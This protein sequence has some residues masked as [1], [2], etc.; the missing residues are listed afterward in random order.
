MGIPRRPTAALLLLAY[1]AAVVGLPLP[2]PARP[3]QEAPPKPTAPSCC[4]CAGSCQCCGCC[5]NEA[6]DETVPD[7]VDWRPAWCALKC[8]GLG[9]SPLGAPIT[10]PP[11]LPAS[12]RPAWPVVGPT[13]PFH[14]SAS[15]ADHSPPD[16]PPRLP[17][18]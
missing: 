3:H 18:N 10:L 16:P 5:G 13:H 1:L 17:V 8:R 15:S 12:W 14:P 2:A 11:P 9:V 4:C 7:S 6:P